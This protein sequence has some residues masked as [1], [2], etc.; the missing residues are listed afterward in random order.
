MAICCVSSFFPELREPLVENW[1]KK[2]TDRKSIGLKGD[3]RREPELLPAALPAPGTGPRSNGRRREIDA[4]DPCY[5]DG[6][7]IHPDLGERER[8]G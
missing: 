4:H 3:P 1:L 2:K 6:H 8:N 7:A 5:I